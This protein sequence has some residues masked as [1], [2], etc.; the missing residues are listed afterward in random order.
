[1]HYWKPCLLCGPSYF[2]TGPSN[3]HRDLGMTPVVGRTRNF[4][5]SDFWTP[6]V[7]PHPPANFFASSSPGHR[8]L[9]PSLP[10][11]FPQPSPQ[12]HSLPWCHP[13]PLVSPADPRG[14]ALL[15][16]PGAN[17]ASPQP[18]ADHDPP[19]SSANPTI[20]RRCLH[21]I[22]GHHRVPSL[23]GASAYM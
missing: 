2:F 6:P 16:G 4:P 17:P 1:M 14:L 10:Y 13:S 7:L 5:G 23:S 12:I 18:G 21:A 9:S 20:G 8:S 11:L 15:G 22:R 19:Q 3:P